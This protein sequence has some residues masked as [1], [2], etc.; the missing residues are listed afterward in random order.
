MLQSRPVYMSANSEI[1]AKCIYPKTNPELYR[2]T[3]IHPYILNYRDKYALC[4]HV[5]S[6]FCN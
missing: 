6:L 5:L 1:R 3:Q 4:V 2:Q